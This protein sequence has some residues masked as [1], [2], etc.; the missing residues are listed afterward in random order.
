MSTALATFNRNLVK[1]GYDPETASDAVPLA[2]FI[3]GPNIK[4]IA[5]FLGKPRRWVAPIAQTLREQRVWVNDTI[6]ADPE[7][8]GIEMALHT[9]VAA[10][11]L[12]A[13][14]EGYS[15]GR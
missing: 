15:D 11:E 3:V 8:L 13:V 5:T 9:L 6:I 2:A 4:R 14:A 12:H 7:N 10:G 1:D